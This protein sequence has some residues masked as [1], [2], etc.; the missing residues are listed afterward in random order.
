[1]SVCCLS[2]CCL[3]AVCLFKEAKRYAVSQ[4]SVRTDCA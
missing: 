4:L 3:S 2:V 1:L